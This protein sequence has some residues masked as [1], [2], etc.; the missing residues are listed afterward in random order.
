[1]DGEE[2]FDL[3][4]FFAALADR[5]RLRL[6][7]LMR[8]GEVCVCFFADALG[9]NNPKISRHLAYLRRAGLVRTRRQ[10]KWMHYSLNRPT[11]GHASAIFESILK[12]F[13][14]DPEMISDVGAMLNIC[15]ALDDALISVGGSR[16][17][18]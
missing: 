8:K 12:S 13:D 17:S 1:M 3:V 9:T 11:D 7:N 4:L 10:G 14:Y 16:T 2:T 5:T 18:G 15:C 6:L